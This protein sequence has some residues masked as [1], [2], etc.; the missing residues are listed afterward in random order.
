[1]TPACTAAAIAPERAEICFAVVSG[2]GAI[3]PMR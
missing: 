1:M 3:P 2:N